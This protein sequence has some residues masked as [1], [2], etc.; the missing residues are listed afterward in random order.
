MTAWLLTWLWQG[1]A[2]AVGVAVALRG[3]RRL[4]APT[5]HLIWWGALAAL[6]WLG[7]ASAPDPSVSAL[8]GCAAGAPGLQPCPAGAEP[9]FYVPSAPDIF[10]ITFIGI[11]AGIALVGLLRLLPSLH[12]VYVLRDR[13]RPFP[14]QIE[15]A[16]PLWLEAKTRGRGA[17][18]M[19]CD[20]VE[21]ATVLGLQRPCIAVAPALV[22]ALTIDELDQVILHEHAHVQR[23]D[24][25]SRLAQALL[26][27]VLWIHP[28]ALFVSRAL[29]REREMACDEWVVARTGLP[30]AYARCLA[31]AAEVQ[32]CMRAR[33]ALV[34]ALVG[35]RHELVRRVDHLL[36]LRGTTRRSVSLAAATAAACAMAVMSAQLQSM[37][38]AEIGDIALPQVVGPMQA[39]YGALATVPLKP[40]STD[41]YAPVARVAVMAPHTPISPDAPIAPITPHAPIAPI[42]THAP[43]APIAPSFTFAGVYALPDTPA[44]DPVVSPNPWSVL[45][46]PG[47]E[48]A[49]AA[50]RTGITVANAVS[51][52]GVSLARSF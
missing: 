35:T 41:D 30:K 39:I 12:A 16:L 43:I 11:W 32:G 25:W 19:I 20:S 37:R 42:T 36:S 23:L 10:I 4:N 52:A 14:P 8:E 24:D 26:L 48:I 40:D 6:A 17:E 13:C 22:E 5:R 51:R 1:A 3:G 38:F 2:L 45:A 31:H 49:S 7:W 29:S 28:A 15:A 33:S 46:E 50:K 34:P 21:G 27:S 9:T 47:V 18:L 44:A